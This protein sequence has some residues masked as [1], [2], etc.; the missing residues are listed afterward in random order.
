MST[1]KNTDAA[2]S[3]ATDTVN[4]NEQLDALKAELEAALNL[5]AELQ[6]ENAK[7]KQQLAAQA[8]SDIKNKKAENLAIPSDVVKHNKKKYVALVAGVMVAGG[9][10]ISTR[11]IAADPELLEE[12]LAVEGQGIFKEVV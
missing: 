2:K 3:G 8:A 6:E 1:N 7:L 4:P 5:V 11:E 12:Y 9:E 10:I